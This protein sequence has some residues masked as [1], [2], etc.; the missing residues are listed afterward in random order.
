MNA[1]KNNNIQQFRELM[2]QYDENY[3]IDSIQNNGWNLLQYVCLNGFTDI[4]VELVTKHKANV[5]IPNTDQW[6]PLHLASYKGH[7][8]IVKVLMS[9]EDIDIN[10]NVPGIGTPLHCACKKNHLQIVSLLLHKANFK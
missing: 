4:A 5:N 3:D 7:V 6:T 8:E 2:D 10:C 1:V 9:V